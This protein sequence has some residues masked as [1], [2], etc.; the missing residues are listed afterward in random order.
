MY[1]AGRWEREFFEGR[2]KPA[3]Q[4]EPTWL[5]CLAL[6]LGPWFGA[7]I[8]VAIAIHLQNMNVYLSYLE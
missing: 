7:A 1:Y 3:R 5:I 6:L 8:S 4:H 2:S